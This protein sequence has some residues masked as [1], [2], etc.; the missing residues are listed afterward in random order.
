[1]TKTAVDVSTSLDGLI[2][3]V[4]AA[5]AENADWA[6]TARLVADQL[7][8]HLPTPDVLTAEQRLGSPDD[9]VG[10]TLH[11]EP[12][13][14]FSI[15][16]LVW[17]PGQLTRIHDHVTWC[18][19]GVIQGVEHEELF[20]ADLTLVGRNENHAGDASGFAPCWVTSTGCATSATRPRS[21]STSTAPTSLASVRPPAATTTDHHPTRRSSTVSR[22]RVHNLAISLDGF[23]TGEP[24]TARDAVRPRGRAAARMDVRHP[25]LGRRSGSRRRRRRRSPQ[26]NSLGIGAEIM[27][28][29]KFGPPGWQDDADW[30][31][32]WGPNPPFHSPT[33][34]LTHRPRPPIEMEGGTTFH[35]LD[36]TPA[37]ALA[38]AQRGRRRPGRADRRRRHGRA[39]LH[40]RRAGRPRAPGA[41]AD[42]ARA[43]RPASGTA[44]RPSRT[45]TTSRRSPPPAA[46]PT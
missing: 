24:Q 14:T 28:A 17:C 33:F 16:G 27:G 21:R 22:A 31:G 29:N 32:W 36:A 1:M 40:R 5:V 9:Y 38:A 18:A 2:G 12:G 41:G 20:D 19:L 8:L 45:P 34:V 7:R 46:S 10:H 30:K 26:R 15:V 3:G 4:R 37:E 43:R 42:R 13:G 11:V 25:L 44:W 6:A 23:A 39:R 35:F